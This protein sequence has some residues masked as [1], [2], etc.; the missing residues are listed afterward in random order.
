MD[1]SICITALT[2][3][4]QH[5]VALIENE[6]PGVRKIEVAF[7]LKLRRDRDTG[8]GDTHVVFSEYCEELR[9]AR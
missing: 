2:V 5:L 4:L 6:V 8:S 1:Q 9:V 3:L 7:L